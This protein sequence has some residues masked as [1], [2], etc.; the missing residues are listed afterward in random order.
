MP[1]VLVL[2]AVA[3]GGLVGDGGVF[4]AIGQVVAGLLATEVEVRL[5]RVA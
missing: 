2:V 1:C 4:A 3:A 5:A